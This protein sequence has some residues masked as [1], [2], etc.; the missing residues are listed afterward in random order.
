[1]CD[2]MQLLKDSVETKGYIYPFERGIS[3]DMDTMQFVV[4]QWAVTMYRK[5]PTGRKSKV[6][7]DW[8]VV[9]GYESKD[10]Q[11]KKRLAALENLLLTVQHGRTPAK[12]ADHWRRMAKVSA[13]T[14]LAR[15]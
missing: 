2:C 7:P 6:K 12:A 4:G 1:M 9:D 14:R 8:D 3:L 15:T 11:D 5:T 13:L 10:T